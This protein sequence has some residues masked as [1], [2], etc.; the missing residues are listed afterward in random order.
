METN[1]SLPHSQVPA[2]YPYPEPVRSSPYP[3]TPF[4]E[5]PYYPPIYFWLSQA[6]SFLQ[7]SP[8]VL[9]TPLFSRIRATCPAH[10]I[11]DFITRTI[12]GEEYRSLSSSLCSFLHAPVTSSLLGQNILFSTLF[13]NTLSLCSSFNVSDQVSHPYKTIGK[14]VC[15]DY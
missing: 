3:H 6:V 12:L 4:P 15:L 11:L 1:G 7:V 14:V 5:G 8:P 13:S 10:P 2:A 9:Y